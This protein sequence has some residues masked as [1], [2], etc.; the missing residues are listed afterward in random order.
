VSGKMYF[1][2]KDDCWYVPVTSK[3]LIQELVQT[4]GIEPVRLSFANEQLFITRLE[5]RKHQFDRMVRVLH[6]PGISSDERLSMLRGIVSGGTDD[7]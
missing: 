5:T 1:S 6:E 3:E 7:S 4:G 2:P